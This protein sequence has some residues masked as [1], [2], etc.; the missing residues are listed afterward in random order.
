M[1]HFKL[2]IR[3]ESEDVVVLI[4][5]KQNFVENDEKQLREYLEAEKAIHPGKKLFA[6][7]PTQ[8]MIK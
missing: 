6:F 7:L 4:E 2:D 5:T 8:T 1:S 3:F